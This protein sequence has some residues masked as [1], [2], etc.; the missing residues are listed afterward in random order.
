MESETNLTEDESRIENRKAESGTSRSTE[1]LDD[2]IWIPKRYCIAILGFLGFANI[3]AL[4]VNMSVAIVSMTSNR[5]LLTN[6]SK[7]IIDAEFPWDRSVQGI[8]LG[9][10]FYGYILTQVLGGWLAIRYG[11]KQLFFC[12][13]FVTAIITL[14]TP[15]LAKMHLYLLIIGRVLEGVFEGVTYPAMHGVWSHWAP[16]TERSRLVTI[17]LSG[18]YFGTV[19]ALPLSGILTDTLGW[20]SIFYVFGTV[21]LIW[22]GIWFYIVAETPSSDKSIS[23]AEKEYIE[24]TIGPTIISSKVNVPW[25]SIMTSLPVWAIVAAHFSENWGFYTLLTELPTFMSD[26]FAYSMYDAGLISALPYLVMGLVVQ[27]S[28]FL[29]DWFRT[30]GHLST[31]QVRKLFTCTAFI[32]QTIFLLAAANATKP[33][34]VI[35]TLTVAVGFGGLAWSGFSVNSLDIA[36]QYASILMGISN[37]VA[38]I[39]GIISPSLTSYVIQDKTSEEWHIV[40]HISAAIYIIGTIIYAFLASGKVQNWAIIGQEQCLLSTDDMSQTSTED[41]LPIGTRYQATQK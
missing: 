39:P 22:C 41:L 16:P 34:S 12:G 9:S 35:A 8:I 2:T 30:S 10:F 27:F 3:Y 29:A 21:A 6:G 26:V 33:I 1:F 38:T 31:M 28:G 32:C 7:I 36:P 5:T 20:S 4:R 24:D 14:L 11:G 17:T 25:K 37:T 18:S 15:L 13:V 23:V 19:I 40:F